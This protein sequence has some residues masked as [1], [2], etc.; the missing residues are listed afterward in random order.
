MKTL[1]VENIAEHRTSARPSQLLR[2]PVGSGQGSDFVTRRQEMPDQR[3]TD[4]T[5]AAGDG[6]LHT[7]SWNGIDHNL[8]SKRPP[9]PV[10]QYARQVEA[11]IALGALAAIFAV[12]Y[13]AFRAGRLRPS[14]LTETKRLEEYDFY[15]FVV[16]EHRRIEFSAERF[17]EAARHFLTTRN[18]TAA[19]ELIVIG[20]QNFVRDTFGSEELDTYRKLYNSFE[21]DSV[22]SDSEAFLENYKRIVTLI[23]RSFP[24]TGIE[25]LLHNLVNPARSLVA[26]ENG[27]V[28][29]RKVEMGATDL[30]LDLKTRKYQDQDKLNYELNLGARKFKCT[31][32]P[33][34]RPD[35]GLVGAI[36][37]N[38]DI[39]FLRDEIRTHPE[40]LESW[41][42]NFLK[43]EFNLE[44]NILSADE[45]QAALKGKRHYLD[46]AIRGGLDNER[47]SQ[48]FA[49][50]FSDIVGYTS[51]MLKN[52][53]AALH[54]LNVSTDLHRGLIAR[55]DG[56]LLKEM[57]DGILASFSS[58]SQA[59]SCARDLQ[60]AVREESDF[61]LRIGIHLGEVTKSG[62][63]VF[64]DGVNI[65]SRIQGAAE[66]GTIAV[67]DTVYRNIKNKEGFVTTDLGL[68][69]L[70]HIDEAVRL[71][72]VEV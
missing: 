29:G 57:G 71:Y 61:R 4:Y 2:C 36:C 9:R 24:N 1:H 11:L 37:I 12:G 60:K 16:N 17:D 45:Y 15:P 69:D 32:I 13:L 42:D 22:I 39:H 26:I 47:S 56:R 72:S 51:M 33:I 35:Y 6:N 55:H 20:E 41:I 14:G 58:V 38:I 67:S 5:R 34:F 25:I 54:W 65:A 7:W 3:P 31:T 18:S 59:V 27:E 66:P 64:G 53:Q 30:V 50:M 48:L 49:I 68:T 10:R 52:E 23:G 46:E 70:K 28:T 63:D 19:R 21:G 43:T 40:K 62:G 8:F 44:E